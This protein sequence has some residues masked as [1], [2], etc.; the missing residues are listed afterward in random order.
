M[1]TCVSRGEEQGGTHPRGCLVSPT[2]T[3]LDE[4]VD[5]RAVLE[6]SIRYATGIDRRDWTLYRSC[7]TDHVNVDF[8]SFTQRPA[9]D[10]PIAA[11]DWVDMVRSTIDGFTSTQHLLGN[12]EIRLQGDGGSYTAAIQ[13]QHWMSSDRWYVIGGWYDNR[14]QRTSDGWRIASCTLHQTWDAGDRGLLRTATRIAAQ[15]ASVAPP[16]TEEIG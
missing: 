8:S 13:A 15:R 9:P 14:V 5:W 1:E 6:L 4:L 11:D 16:S 10:T 2:M 3:T 7:F 12:Q